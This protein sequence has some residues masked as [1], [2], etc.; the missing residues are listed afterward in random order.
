MTCPRPTDKDGQALYQTASGAFVSRKTDEGGGLSVV[1]HPP[2]AAA[3][4]SLRVTR[5]VY[6]AVATVERGRTVTLFGYVRSAVSGAEPAYSC[7]EF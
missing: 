5:A 3:N 4:Q 6:D 1:I 7:V 2:E